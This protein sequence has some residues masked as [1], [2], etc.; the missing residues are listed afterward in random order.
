MAMI[1]VAYLIAFIILDYFTKQ[2]EELPGVVAWYPPAGLTYA[3][4]LVFGI[5][6]GPAVTIALLIDSLFIYR[7]PQPPYLLFL[8]AVIISLIYTVAAA[9]LRH[10]IRFD[11]RLRRLRDV[12]W[13]VVTT[14]FVSA[15]LAVLTVSSSALSSDMPQSE[16]LRAIFQWWIGETVG[17]LTVTPFLLIYV[18]PWLKRFAEGQPV[19]LPV[20]RSFLRPTLSAIGQ[21]ASIALVLYWVFGARMLD[22][23]QPMY[24]ITLPLIWIALQRGFKGVS[25][26][27]L[28]LNSGVVFALWLFRFDL[29]R[30]GELEL[31]MIVNCIVGLLMGAIVTERMQAESQLVENHATLN[32]LLESAATPVFSL[33]RDYRYTSFNSAHAAV[34]KALYGAEIEIGQ[35]M[36][37]YQTVPE[38]REEARKNLDRALRGEQVVEFSYSGEPGRTRR[39]FEVAHNPIR[40]TA[41][42]VVGVSVF[43]SDLTERKRA[44]QEIET[45]SRF[46]SENP[47]PVLRVEQDG[48][49]NYANLSSESL[50]HL[51][52]CTVGEYLP[53]D[54]RERVANAAKSNAHTIVN[55]E[56]EDRVYSIM[57]VP[58]TDA[59]YVNL[60]GRDITERK[61]TEERIQRQLEHLTALSAI[62]QV[63]ASILEIKLCLSEILTHV[64]KE[65]GI[66]AA[67][68]LI[69]NSGLQILEFGA[70]R[71]FR[72]QA[73]IRKTRVRLGE[74][75]AG[76]VALERQLVHVPNLRDEPDP[77]FLTTHFTGEGFVCYFGV[78]LIAKGQVQGVLEIFHRAAFEPDAEWL[79]FLN[80][81]ADQAAIAIE[82]ITLFSDLQR[83]NVDLTL[84]YDATIE[85]WSHALDLRD[86]ETEGHS[87]RVTEM[88]VKIARLFGLT[89][90]DLVQVRWG[91]LL[92]DIG[93]LGVP[94][95]ILLKPD[96]L[97]NEEWV[98]MKKHPAFAYEMLSPIRYL[99]L[100]LDIPYCHHE[101]WDGTGYPR[102]LR[103]T[104]IPLTARIFA[105]VDVWDALKSDRPYRDGWT[106]EKVREHIRASSGTHFDPQ[107][108]DVFMQNQGLF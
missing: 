71:G 108:V 36:L 78:P 28:A 8:W 7:M 58:V 100:A 25:A 49:I 31:L 18:M 23:F 46:P 37:E 104:Q 96:P 29:A 94:D 73:V 1:V 64:T 11:W 16:V 33:D 75:Y 102:G 30:L 42:E 2:F 63:I 81:L 19:R 84:A 4:L 34:M 14:I 82:N 86:K 59:G 98:A 26:A 27:I 93:K 106:E 48:K 32:A 35:R 70:E 54:L 51:W 50:L 91:A 90:A 67:D 92:H 105:V 107:V 45:L 20:R 79:D 97:T 39:Y 69:I 74:S 80:A 89:D 15:L 99:R 10:R 47:N 77:L 13:L 22:E 72:N 43:V 57:V 56:C 65:L 88:T 85:G 44:E 101:K 9:F 95:G 3:L 12:T 38:D 53:P 55:I 103:G 40:D 17:V 76:R 66:D 24:L 68:I 60:Y 52:N 41:E 83:S 61:Q 6:Y 21:V 62:D 5:R 87:K